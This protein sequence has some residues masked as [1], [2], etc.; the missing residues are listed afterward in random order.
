MASAPPHTSLAELVYSVSHCFPVENVM[1]LDLST[2]LPW[3][4]VV[5][6]LLSSLV[7]AEPPT[8]LL[9]LEGY[10]YQFSF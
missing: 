10:K 2:A 7:C 8:L 4:H 1:V 3:H 9:K 6:T 5:R